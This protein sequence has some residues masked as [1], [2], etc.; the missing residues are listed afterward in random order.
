MHKSWQRTAIKTATRSSTK[1]GQ[2]GQNHGG[3][4]KSDYEQLPTT[5]DPHSMAENAR[6]QVRRRSIWPTFEV[7]PA[8]SSVDQLHWA[9]SSALRRASSHS[10]K[11][12]L[13]QVLAMLT[14]PLVKNGVE[15][16]L[17]HY[18]QS[19]HACTVLSDGPERNSRLR[20]LPKSFEQSSHQSSY[21]LRN[22]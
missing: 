9:S 5:D 19:E 1:S 6:T 4:C 11:H 18:V 7:R 3:I 16:C 14:T 17:C 12:V 8:N 2:I 13:K 20:I 21:S 10:K 22:D 15:V